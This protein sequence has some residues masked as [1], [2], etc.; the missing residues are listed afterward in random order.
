[1]S[2]GTRSEAIYPKMVYPHHPDGNVSHTL[3]GSPETAGFGGVI[4]QDEDE[5]KWVMDGNKLEDF[6]KEPK[7][8]A[9]PAGW[10]K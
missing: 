7:E 4:V 6:G 5:E 3:A 10:D 1:M 9:K 2:E 8:A